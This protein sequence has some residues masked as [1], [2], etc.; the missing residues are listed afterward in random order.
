[1]LKYIIRRIISLVISLILISV[2]TF[3]AFSVIP[4][5]AVLAKLGTNATP[6]RVAQLRTEMG[7]DDPIPVRYVNWLKDALHGD[8][9]EST[10]YTGNSVQSLMEQRLPFTLTLCLMSFAVILA[11]S[12]PLGVFAARKK[13]SWING[14]ITVLTQVAMAIPSFF[15]GILLTFVFGIVLKVFQPGKFVSPSQ[16]FTGSLQFLLLPAIATALP[17]IAMT[18]KFL[19]NSILNEMNK[20]YVRTARIK[21]NTESRVLYGHVLKNALIPV[22]TFLG[23][24]LADV[25]AG[26]IIVEQVFNV[27]GLGR[28]LVTAISNRDFPVV[29]AVVLFVTAFVIVV[30]FVVDM[31]Y[32][33]IDPRVK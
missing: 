28:L 22:V 20:N 21:G 2:I 19:R 16:D 13:D 27:P 1:M 7:L 29:Q 31:M 25:L 6:E 10:Q 26:N 15:L 5:D 8:F 9:G 32:K 3:A 23:L 11:F 4:G 24:V 12:I 18:V 33:F 14:L 17:K 30:N